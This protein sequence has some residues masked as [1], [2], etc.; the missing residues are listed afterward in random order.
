[1][2]RADKTGDPYVVGPLG[3]PLTL[4]QL[5]PAG[6]GHWVPRRKAEVVAAVRGGLLTMDEALQRYNM[7]IEE[8][9]G[10]ERAVAHFGLSGLRTTQTTQYRALQERRQ[11]F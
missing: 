6:F 8:Y 1:M 4:K 2:I 3:Q 9:A 11:K 7:T 5:P 10:W